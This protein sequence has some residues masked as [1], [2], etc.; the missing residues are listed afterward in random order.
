MKIGKT[1]LIDRISEKSGFA[2][3]DVNEMFNAFTAVIT[4]AVQHGDDIVIPGFGSW[5]VQDVKERV[6]RNIHTNETITIPA[7]KRVKFTAGKTLKDAV[8][9]QKINIKKGKKS[10]KKK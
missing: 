4:D 9:N 2:K 6:G 3:K 8:A 5:K 10:S 7:G 1:D